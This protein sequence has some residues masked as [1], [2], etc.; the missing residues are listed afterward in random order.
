MNIE[1]ELTILEI[2]KDSLEKELVQLGAIKKGDFF[3][4]R[5]V[6]DF[7]PIKK[8]KWIRLRDNGEKTTLTIK[9]IKDKN[10]IGGTTELEI[11]VS[12][13]EKTNLILNELGYKVRAYQENKRTTYT[14]GSVNFDIDKWPMIPTYVEIEGKTEES[15]RKALGKITYNKDKVTTYDVDSIYKNF[16]NIDISDIKELK[17]EA[18]K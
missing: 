16:Y 17:F 6:Y 8:N 18:K 13:F 14:L 5:Y 7:N 10:I 3:Q 2:N 9:E 15:V 12:D 1:N 11:E 4:R